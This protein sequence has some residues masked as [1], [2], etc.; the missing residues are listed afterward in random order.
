MSIGS[1]LRSG[2]MFTKE[3]A[4]RAARKRL[5]KMNIW[6]VCLDEVQ[7]VPDNMDETDFRGLVSAIVNDTL[8]WEQ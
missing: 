1:M 7:T 4:I 8:Y 3:Q 2:E 5:R 6:V